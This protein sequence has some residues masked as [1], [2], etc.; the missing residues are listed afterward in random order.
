MY[1]AAMTM[2]TMSVRSIAEI[3]TDLGFSDQ[4]HFKCVF[5]Q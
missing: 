5:W 4:S 3:V 1:L 2:L